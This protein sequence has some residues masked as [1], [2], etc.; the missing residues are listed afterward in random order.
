MKLISQKTW[1]ITRKDYQK[2]RQKFYK[3]K[4]SIHQ[5]HI[6][7]NEYKTNSRALRYLKEK[8]TELKGEIGKFTIIIGDYSL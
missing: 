6:I 8:L 4:G 2:E 7:L 1:R 3:D 5:E